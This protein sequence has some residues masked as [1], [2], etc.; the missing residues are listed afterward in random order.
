[1]ANADPVRHVVIAMSP[2]SARALTDRIRECLTASYELLE[3]AWLSGAWY[4][5]GYSSW[6]A[7][8]RAEFEGARMLS[9]P[10]AQRQEICR[11]LS[12]AGMSQR[13]IASGLGV[14]Q[15]TVSNDLRRSTT[16]ETSSNVDQG[17]RQERAPI[18]PTQ[19]VKA[20]EQTSR[21]RG[22]FL[23]ETSPLRR[24][25]NE[26]ARR[27]VAEDF[28]YADELHKALANELWRALHAEE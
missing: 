14:D 13:E 23:P 19:V 1:M 15:K 17:T 21:P 16:E 20:T 18:I 2:E 3:R 27:L 22:P 25:A 24:R 9:P 6:D 5:L 10:R 26:E 11:Q 8:C 12:D 7:Y 4:V 28:D